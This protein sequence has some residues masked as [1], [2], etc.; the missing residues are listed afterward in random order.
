M[1]YKT[2]KKKNEVYLKPG[3]LTI[4]EVGIKYIAAVPLREHKWKTISD[5]CRAYI[6][7]DVFI[8]AAADTETGVVQ[9]EKIGVP[10]CSKCHLPCEK[11]W[12]TIS[13]LIPCLSRDY[14]Q[15]Y[16]KMDQF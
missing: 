6:Q 2:K 3:E 5:C 4:M 14:D 1:A 16:H 13:R 9:D 10:T 8:D 12:T 15:Q 11:Q 7:R